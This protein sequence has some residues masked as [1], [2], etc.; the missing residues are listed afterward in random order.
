MHIEMISSRNSSGVKG[1]QDI[2]V[3]HW[4]GLKRTLC[5]NGPVAVQGFKMTKWPAVSY[6]SQILRNRR[7]PSNSNYNLSINNCQAI[8][9]SW[10]AVRV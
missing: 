6:F 7:N 4:P 3:S 1:K 9:E 8:Q 5:L 2:T 10:S